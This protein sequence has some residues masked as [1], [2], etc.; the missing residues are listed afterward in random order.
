MPGLIVRKNQEINK[1]RRDMD[2]LFDRLWNEFCMPPA[3]TSVR[4][5]PCIDLS[6]TETNLVLRAEIPG[7]NEDD[8]DV[9]LAGNVL[10]IKGEIKEEVV[11]DS[12]SYHRTERRYGSFSRSIQLPCK[13]EVE[14]IQATYEKGVLNITMPKCQPEKSREV[15]I[16]INR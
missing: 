4:M 5:R 8:L 14:D 9:S 12:E 1:L 2:R 11:R 6:E 13:V 16:K 15:K 10:T 3:P 7:V